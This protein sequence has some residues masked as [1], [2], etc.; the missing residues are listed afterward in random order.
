MRTTIRGWAATAAAVAALA[1]LPAAS[2]IAQVR[3][4]VSV[5]FPGVAVVAGAPLL[6]G[7][8]RALYYGPY[9]YPAYAGPGVAL[10][11]RWV[12]YGRYGRPYGWHRGWR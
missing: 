7:A 8:P 9:A 6:V 3:V 1:T 5:G 11:Y 12:G 10:G 2:S 4:G